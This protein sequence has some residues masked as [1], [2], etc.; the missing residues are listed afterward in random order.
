MIELR[1]IRDLDSNR[2][3]IIELPV[4]IQKQVEQVLESLDESYGVET[5]REYTGSKVFVLENEEDG[6]EIQNIYD[7]SD[8]EFIQMI[9]TTRGE[10]IYALIVNSAEVNIAIFGI[11]EWINV[12]L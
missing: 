2:A 11:R 12:P 5:E 10:Y 4:E 1:T 3:K 9:G 7:F 6:V 8:A